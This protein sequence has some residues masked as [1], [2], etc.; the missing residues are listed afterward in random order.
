MT[1]TR[2]GANRTV[3]AV[4]AIAAT[5]AV[6]VLVAGCSSGSKGGA[7]SSNNPGSPQNPVTTSDSDWKPVADTL[8]RTGKL[9]D[10]NTAY[11]VAL[12]R[13]DLQVTSYGVAIKPGLSLGG[14]A[15]FARYANN[16]TLLMGDLVVT[17]TELPKVTDALQAHGI[18]Q[19]ALHKHLLDQTPPVWWTHIHGMGDAIQLAQALKAVLDATA[20]G[21]A[22]ATPA[23]QP[24]VDID[25]AG[26]QQALGR[27]GTLDNGLFKY[28]I[29]RKDTIVE[30][31]H[32][33]P[34]TSLNLTTVIN[35]QPVGDGKAAINGDFIL[36]DPEVQNVIRALRAGNIQIVELHN[37][38]LTEQPRL[39][40]M[41]FWAVDDAVTLARTLRPALDATNLQPA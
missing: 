5:V 7:G 3:A 11:R 13:T 17:E 41:H 35:F 10:N 1:R 12:T 37:H 32:V 27:K 34:A 38:G 16:E 19:T 33:L 9:G 14:Y 31:G 21:P 26:I 30:D 15:A 24:P 18:A 4:T 25:T 6:V 22:A 2:T 39:F 36:T 23:Q 20:F 8:G 29:T 40:Y 28:S